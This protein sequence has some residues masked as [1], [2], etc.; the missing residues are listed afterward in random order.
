MAEQLMVRL[1]FDNNGELEDVEPLERGEKVRLGNPGA[2]VD[3]NRLLEGT[4]IKYF[5]LHPILYG[6]G[7]PECQVYQTSSG[8]IRICW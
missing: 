6:F 8:Y 4:S 2:A 7:N 5:A 1:I 3:I